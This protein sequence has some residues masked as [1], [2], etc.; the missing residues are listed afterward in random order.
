MPTSL[1]K[2]EFRLLNYL[3]ALENVI[4]CDI[5]FKSSVLVFWAHPLLAEL[6]GPENL[7]PCVK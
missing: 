2:M 6:A 4:L 5:L 1:L 3:G 7:N